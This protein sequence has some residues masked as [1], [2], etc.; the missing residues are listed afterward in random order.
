MS[1]V[2]EALDRGV[3]DRVHAFDLTV[4]PGTFGLGEAMIDIVA[5]AGRDESMCP[6]ELLPL[7]LLL[8]VSRGPTVGPD[9]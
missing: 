8:D 7:D 4:D 2:V 9:R 5:G 3:L 6:E 1:L